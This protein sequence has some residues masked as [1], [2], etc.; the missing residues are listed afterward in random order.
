MKDTNVTGASSTTSNMAFNQ[1]EL[2]KRTTTTTKEFDKKGKVVKEI[3]TVVEEVKN[4]QPYIY[5]N[6]G[7]AGSI[8]QK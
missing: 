3:V 8:I 2:V 1:R 5:T 7:S 4:R 6:T